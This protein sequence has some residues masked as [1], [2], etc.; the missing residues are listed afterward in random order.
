VATEEKDPWG[1]H[2]VCTVAWAGKYS[3]CEFDR[4]GLRCMR[5]GRLVRRGGRIRN[6]A[7]RQLARS[8]PSSVSIPSRNGIIPP[9]GSKSRMHIPTWIADW[10]V[11]SPPNPPLIPRVTVCE[12]FPVL[13]AVSEPR[14][15]I[16]RG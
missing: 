10:S 14:N 4:E 15:E 2:S 8:E 16:R 11:E 13:G 3:G 9:A 5:W 6:D 7:N 1:C 12:L